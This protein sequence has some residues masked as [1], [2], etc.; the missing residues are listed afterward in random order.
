M[1][2]DVCPACAGKLSVPEDAVGQTVRCPACDRILSVSA[3]GLTID[4][5]AAGASPREAVSPDSIDVNRENSKPAIGPGRRSA[6][7]FGLPFRVPPQS[8]WLVVGLLLVLVVLL[9]RGGGDFYELKP[10]MPETE[11]KD[12][13]GKPL[14]ESGDEAERVCVWV[15]PKKVRMPQSKEVLILTFRNGKLAKTAYV[16]FGQLRVTSPQDPPLDKD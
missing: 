11:I 7:P 13:L 16:P 15:A 9:G 8:I 5:R 12:V 10:G 14:T 3:N 2:T 6:N 4:D 1:A